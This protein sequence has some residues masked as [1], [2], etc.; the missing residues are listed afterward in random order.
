LY[1]GTANGAY[2]FAIDVGNQTSYTISGFLEGVDYKFAVTAY[3]VY[4]LESAF[5]DEASYPG[6]PFVTIP[7][8]AGLN[9]IS[10]PLQLF[11]PSISALTEQLSPC[12][13]QVLAYT[14]DAEGYDTWLY[15]DPSMPEQT[16]LSTMDAGKGYWVDMACP[17]EMTVVGNRT[18]NP[19]ALIPGL[20]LVG[21]NS[22]T[23]LPVS[24]ALASI[25]N[26][27][28][29]VWGYKD[30]QWTFYDP[31]DQ[32]GS[33][34]QVLTPG[35]G[36][37]IEVLEDT[38]WTLPSVVT[39]SLTAGLNLISLPLEP[40]NSSISALTEQLSPCLIEVD[41][42][43]YTQ[44]SEGNDSWLFY[45]PSQLDQSTLSTMESGKGYWVDMACPGEMSVVG[46]RTTNPI[47]LVPGLNLVGYSSLTPLPVSQALS[48]IANQYN[49]VWGYKDDEWIYYDP[50]DGTGSTL[51]VLTPGSGYWIE[52]I[53]E[54]VWTLP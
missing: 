38:I 17:G 5:S 20:N 26:K 2:G 22:L 27:Y 35:S 28:T 51:Q 24:E 33:T 21:Y 25:A 47:T 8:S 19:I 43:T 50:A 34:L 31:A 23:P 36:Y 14:R 18:T 10:L 52:A 42:Y 29:F 4:G 16:T 1:Y 12:L 41:A 54:T 15:Y 6:P 46:N 44:D 48:S 11:N 13:F 32:T 9:L 39:V 40:L 53:E 49:F 30:D 45:D 3:N 7:L 37:W